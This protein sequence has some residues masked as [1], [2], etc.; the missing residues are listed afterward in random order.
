MGFSAIDDGALWFCTGLD[1]YDH[2]VCE[3]H[4]FLCK[5]Q[6]G[7]VRGFSPSRGLRQGDPLSP[8]LFLFCV[9]GFSA[10]LKK[11][12]EEGS[13]KGVSFGSTAPHS[14]TS[15]LRMIVLF[16]L[17]DRMITWLC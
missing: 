3:I 14:H 9:E 10:L 12:Q 15:C 6:W 8:Y 16:S 13:I 17:K 5:A 11:A 4:N 7:S 2:A 1:W